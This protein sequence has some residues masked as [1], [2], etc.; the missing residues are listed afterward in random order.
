MATWIWVNIC[1][2]NGLL[3][4]GTKS[5]IKPMLIC[6]AGF[7]R[8]ANPRH[9]FEDYTFTIITTSRRGQWVNDI[10]MPLNHPLAISAGQLSFRALYRSMSGI[11]LT[12]ALF[13]AAAT[14]D[15]A[16]KNSNC[17]GWGEYMQ[18]TE[19]ISLKLEVDNLLSDERLFNP[20]EHPWFWRYTHFRSVT[21]TGSDSESKWDELFSSGYTDRDWP[22]LGKYE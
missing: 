16:G 1:S 20:L 10:T 21:R 4:D 15:A 14:A 9:V 18:Y 8:S 7:T 12:L 3:P 6:I 11:V 13:L 22:R 2:G 5:L 17:V 19:E